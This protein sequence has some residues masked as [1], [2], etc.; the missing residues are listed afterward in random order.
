MYIPTPFLVE[1]R[2]VIMT[3]MQQFDFSAAVSHS[4][5]AGL[6]ASQVPVL[7]REVGPEL[8]IVGHV[9]RGNSHWRCMQPT[10]PVIVGAAADARRELARTTFQPWPT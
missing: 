5:A 8:H 6:V 4:G 1:G 9:V 7:I 10:A 2:K 3:F